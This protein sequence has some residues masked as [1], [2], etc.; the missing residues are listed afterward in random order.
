MAGREL[1][2][3]QGDF[4]PTSDEPAEL[5][6]LIAIR[7]T[8]L[9]EAIEVRSDLEVK[10]DELTTK[11]QESEHARIEAE[12]QATTLQTL[13]ADRERDLVAVRAEREDL[14]QTVAALRVEQETRVV[15][16]VRSALAQAGAEHE[17][18]AGELRR[19]R[20]QLKATVDELQREATELGEVRSAEPASLAEQ[21]AAMVED[22]ADTEARPARPFMASLTRME[23]EARGVLRVPERAGD[24]PELLTVAPGKVDPGQLSTIRM[25]FRILPPAAAT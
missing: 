21:F 24:P 18:I 11:Y 4:D 22:L 20:D 15:E 13:I 25:E 16:A 3:I 2:E 17:T 10:V 14:Q 23:V 7:E 12:A 8:Q 5:Q 1:P 19:E 6:T 9:G